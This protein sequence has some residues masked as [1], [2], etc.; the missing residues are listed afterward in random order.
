MFIHNNLI[1]VVGRT[2]WW[3]NSVLRDTLSEIWAH[4]A[5]WLILPEHTNNPT[6]IQ[7][8]S[9]NLLA[10]CW[11]AKL[12][13]RGLELKSAQRE[14][15]HVCRSS[16]NTLPS[17]SYKESMLAGKQI[18]E[19]I[20][21]SSQSIRNIRRDS[22]TTG[23]CLSLTRWLFWERSILRLVDLVFYLFQRTALY[24]WQTQTKARMASYLD[25]WQESDMDWHMVSL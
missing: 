1:Y 23:S 20:F 10:T 18:H 3:C 13:Q 15:D 14:S 9:N 7:T 8:A 22:W 5:D 24:M 16:G 17:I 2:S 21:F 4:K 12:R 11:C 6:H 25:F 19:K